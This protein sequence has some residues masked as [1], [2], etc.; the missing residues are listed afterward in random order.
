MTSYGVRSLSKIIGIPISKYRLN[1][2]AASAF[3]VQH[4]TPLIKKISQIPKAQYGGRHAVTMLP[5][6]GIGPELMQHVA[7]IFKFAGCPI[8]FEVI[9][10]DKHSPDEEM[11]YA[12]TSI[13]RN[14]VAIKGNIETGKRTLGTISRN[15]ALRNELDLYVNVLHCKS[16]PALTARQKNIDIVIIRQNTEGEYAM[17]EH[18]SA[19]GIVESMKVVT[20]SN[21]ERVARYAFDYARKNGR[22]TITTIHKANI[23]KL[24]D[25]LF[26][27]T[28]RRIAKE[29]PDINHNDMI[30]DNCC[31]QL[32]SKPEQ[33]DVMMMT[34]LYG[35]IVSNVIC[36]L[37]GGAG[38]LSGR[39]YGDH[40]AVF[41]PGTRNTGTAIAGKNIANP[42]AMLNASVDM[43]EHLGHKQH[44]G[45]LR[46]AIDKTISIDRIHTPDLGGTYTSTDVVQ[47]IINNIANSSQR[48][49]AV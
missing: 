44:A 28:S 46:R 30:I 11:E 32:V 23:M 36:G 45:I 6:A 40:Y 31:M 47:S 26:L 18:E 2:S 10:V 25:G 20:A 14:G 41:E 13:K 4:K 48:V 22:K 12:T 38:L 29:Y 33:F 27:E 21:S 3:D 24:S 15:V 9:Q 34:N 8:D 16:V 42:I 39:N 1:S 5:G 17:L 35:T 7:D 37:V 19:H 49:W 43:L